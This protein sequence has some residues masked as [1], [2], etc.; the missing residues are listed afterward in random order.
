MRLVASTSLLRD[1]SRTSTCA[2]AAAVVSSEFTKTCMPSLP[3]KAVS[4][5]SETMNHCVASCVVVV[6]GSTPA[7]RRHHHIDAGRQIADRL[8]D[9]ERRG[10][11]GVERLL[12]RELAL[13]DLRAALSVR[14]S[15]S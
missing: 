3:E 13:P 12:D 1:S 4:P 15:M 11:V 14:R 8:V 6:A 10:D 5:R 2:A 7:G 9:R